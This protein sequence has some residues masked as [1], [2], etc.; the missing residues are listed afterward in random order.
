MVPQPTTPG[1]SLPSGQGHLPSPIVTEVTSLEFL[2]AGLA[3]RIPPPLSGTNHAEGPPAVFHQ[4]VQVL[5]EEILSIPSAGW[6]VTGVGKS[7]DGLP[8]VAGDRYQQGLGYD[9]GSPLGPGRPTEVYA[10]YLPAPEGAGTAKRGNQGVQTFIK[11]PSGRVVTPL[12]FTFEGGPPIQDQQ[13]QKT[14]FLIALASGYRA[15]Q[16]PTLTRHEA[17]SKF[18]LDRTSL[19]LTPSHPHPCSWLRMNHRTI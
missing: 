8:G 1:V 6:G 9:S 13:L 10:E 4:A 15:S 2:K 16:L 19:T 11:T 5:L 18:A 17:F 7:S 14:A 3:G 12:H